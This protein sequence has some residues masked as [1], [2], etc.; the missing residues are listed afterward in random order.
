MND[1]F[2]AFKETISRNNQNIILDLF[3][4]IK[5]KYPSC[6]S[7]TILFIANEMFEYEDDF[8][9]NKEKTIQE[10]IERLLKG[11]AI[12]DPSYKEYLRDIYL[13]GF[14]VYDNMGYI[15]Y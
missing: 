12:L 8:I 2:D 11:S 6:E 15:L 14:D 4:T 3:F 7:Y 5:T 13:F 10:S 1:K 9:E